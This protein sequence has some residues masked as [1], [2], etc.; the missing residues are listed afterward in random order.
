MNAF[1]GLG[2][3]FSGTS[4]VARLRQRVLQGLLK[5][6]L[7]LPRQA[8]VFENNDDR[9]LLTGNGAVPEREAR[10]ISGIG[11]DITEYPAVAEPSGP[12][13]V[14]L[15]SR[16][17]REK[18][19]EYFVEAARQLKSRGVTARFL[20]VGTPDPFNPGSISE[21]QLKTWNAAGTV[22]WA[23]F[24]RDMPSVLQSAHIVCLPTYYREGVPRILLEGAASA[25]ALV[26]TDTP[27]CRD[28]VQDGVNG[29]LVPTHDV[30][31][32]AAALEKLIADGELR[33]RMGMAGR[34]LVERQFSLPYVLEQFWDLYLQL[35]EPAR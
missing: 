4:L 24:R 3:T 32:L 23:G 12:P 27:G 19:V 1:A 21:A 16:M 35:R 25:R 26:A 8:I 10:V 2:F 6:S 15:A 17:L 13:C 33:R 11:V 34:A 29:L 30:D 20:L 31:S 28:I 14:V 18:G 9:L 7:R 22:E 5:L